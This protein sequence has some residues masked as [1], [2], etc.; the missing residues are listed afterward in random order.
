MIK[1]RTVYRSPQLMLLELDTHE[2]ICTSTQ[3]EDLQTQDFDFDAEEY[4]W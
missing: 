2:I 4:E 1:N 3:L